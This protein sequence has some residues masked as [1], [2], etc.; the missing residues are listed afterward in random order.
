[1]LVVTDLDDARETI[2]AWRDDYNAVR[3]HSALGNLT[4]RDFVERL[5]Q[6]EALSA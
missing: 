2:A 6:P 1:V 4:P 5:R 3:P